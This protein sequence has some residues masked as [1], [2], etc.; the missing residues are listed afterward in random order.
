MICQ[1]FLPKKEYMD[2]VTEKKQICLHH[3]V[4]NP[5]GGADAVYN[6]W[7][8][9]PQ[10]VA[11]HYVIDYDGNVYQLIPSE[12]WAHHLGIKARNNTE[13]NKACI[14]IELVSWGGLVKKGD[15]YFIG[16]EWKNNA[17]QPGV[18][19][20]EKETVVECNHRGFKHF[21]KYSD[22]QIES[23]SLLLPQ[24]CEENNIP[25]NYNSQMWDL[26]Q[27]AL[28]GEAGIFTHTSYRKDKSDCY[29]DNRLIEMLKIL[30]K[31]QNR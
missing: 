1:K 11:T 3:T 19:R 23:L 15:D 13:L 14:G 24:L 20:V 31:N 25:S 4:S 10:R 7:A 9:D 17:I 21:Q 18:L 30:S 5:I 12:N 6:W 28:N 22:K 2:D 29:P 27:N 8:F 16:G 26:S